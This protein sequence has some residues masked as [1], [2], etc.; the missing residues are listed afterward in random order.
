M[1]GITLK[2]GVVI[3]LV[4]EAM[5]VT[6][7]ARCLANSIS[8]MPITMPLGSLYSTRVSESIT[9]LWKLTAKFN[10]YSNSSKYLT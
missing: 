1:Q 8:S 2:I 7:P 10:S 9:T 5:K 4:V 3:N 6:R